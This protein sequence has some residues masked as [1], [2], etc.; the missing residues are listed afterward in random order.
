MRSDHDLLVD[1]LVFEPR[2][3]KNFVLPFPSTFVLLLLATK[4]PCITLA[5]TSQWSM[6]AART[7]QYFERFVSFFPCIWHA[8]HFLTNDSD[9]SRNFPPVAGIDLLLEGIP[10]INPALLG[11]RRQSYQMT[12]NPILSPEGLPFAPGLKPISIHRQIIWLVCPLIFAIT[13]NIPFR[14]CRV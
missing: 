1:V 14:W 2:L 12:S 10:Q 11:D 9:S 8:C 6:N 13:G 3:V 7:S 4:V 5:S